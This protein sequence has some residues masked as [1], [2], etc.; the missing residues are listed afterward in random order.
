ME[1]DRNFNLYS[2]YHPKYCEDLAPKV[3]TSFP[4]GIFMK[5]DKIIATAKGRFSALSRA[6]HDRTSSLFRTT[7]VRVSLPVELP[8]DVKS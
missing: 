4:K 5:L 6:G 1:T 7:E 8:F 3:S 2:I